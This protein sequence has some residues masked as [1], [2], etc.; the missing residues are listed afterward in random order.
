M[1]DSMGE[2][3]L[4]NFDGEAFWESKNHIKI[5]TLTKL[6]HDLAGQCP[7]M[8]SRGPVTDVI[9]LSSVNCSN[10]TTSDLIDLAPRVTGH[11]P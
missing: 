8:T 6:N 10:V 5:H 4:Y 11:S 9:E 2:E 7:L 1:A 3:T